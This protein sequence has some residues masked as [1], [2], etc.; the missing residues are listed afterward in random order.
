MIGVMNPVESFSGHPFGLVGRPSTYNKYI[1]RIVFNHHAQLFI[2]SQLDF[3]IQ[4]S[5]KLLYL[6]HI[7]F[8]VIEVCEVTWKASI[9]AA[10]GNLHESRLP[11]N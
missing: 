5:L 4:S 8:G 6:Q 10:V 11:T 7:T 2:G 1:M 9:S 3:N